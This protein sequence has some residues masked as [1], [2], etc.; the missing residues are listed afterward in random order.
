M[1]TGWRFFLIV[2]ILTLRLGMQLIP[3]FFIFFFT[4]I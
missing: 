1:L 2:I 4:A 3:F